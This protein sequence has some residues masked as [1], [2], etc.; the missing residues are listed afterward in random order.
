MRALSLDVLA[1]LTAF[2][3]AA[4]APRVSGEACIQA[5]VHHVEDAP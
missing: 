2:A 4:G 1:F 3:L 5:T